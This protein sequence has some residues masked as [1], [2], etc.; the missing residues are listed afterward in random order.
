[1]PLYAIC[2][3]WVVKLDHAAAPLQVALRSLVYGQALLD[4]RLIRIPLHRRR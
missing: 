4:V 3:V 2:V 1:M